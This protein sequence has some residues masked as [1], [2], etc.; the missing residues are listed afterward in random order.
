M[1]FAVVISLVESLYRR[2]SLCLHRYRPHRQFG[3]HFQTRVE[4]NDLVAF[5]RASEE[6]LSTM[7]TS[8]GVNDTYRMY[9]L[10]R[11]DGVDFNLAAIG[12]DL[13]IPYKGPFAPCNRCL[14]TGIKKAAPGIGGRRC[15]RVMSI[16]RFEES[17][18]G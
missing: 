11:R 3:T 14:T 9:L 8:S 16:R 2:N 13:N 1:T 17:G 10:A 7:T 12:D 5:C 4:H 15:H 18:L 6:A